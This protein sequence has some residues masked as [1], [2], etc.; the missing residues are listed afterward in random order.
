MTN[1]EC[2]LKWQYKVWGILIDIVLYKIVGNFNTRVLRSMTSVCNSPRCSLFACLS[3]INVL[4]LLRNKKY[5]FKIYFLCLTNIVHF[6]KYINIIAK[7]SAWSDLGAFWRNEHT[8][9][10][11]SAAV[12][13]LISSK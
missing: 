3:H 5:L 6:W 10:C 11:T 2:K 12:T 1:Y 9:T 4:F 7:Y 8:L 13:T